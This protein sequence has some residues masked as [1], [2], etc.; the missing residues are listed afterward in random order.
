MSNKNQSTIL[1]LKKYSMAILHI[2][3]LYSKSFSWGTRLGFGMDHRVSGG[4]SDHCCLWL[5]RIT[6][7]SVPVPCLMSLSYAAI[8]LFS[9]GF[10]LFAHRHLFP[11]IFRLFCF[12]FNCTL[13]QLIIVFFCSPPLCS[14]LRPGVVAQEPVL[15]C[16]QLTCYFCPPCAKNRTSW[17]I[18]DTYPAYL[19]SA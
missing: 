1:T 6:L 19:S 17:I 18:S 4:L 7:M 13:P 2:S 5:L 10:P 3:Y 8:A 14:G 11:P 12:S 16:L 15:T 9:W